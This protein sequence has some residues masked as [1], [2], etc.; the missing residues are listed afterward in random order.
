MTTASFVARPLLYCAACG[1]AVI[2][3]QLTPRTRQVFCVMRGCAQYDVT[4]TID[5]PVIT[6]ISP[7][8]VHG[9]QNIVDNNPQPREH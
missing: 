3:K 7:D 4:A 2:V 1:A 8:I 9:L 5:D 6:H